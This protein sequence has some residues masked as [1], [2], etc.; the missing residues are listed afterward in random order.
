[1]VAQD[2]R[3]V[4]DRQHDR[5]QGAIVRA[6]EAVPPLPSSRMPSR[7]KLLSIVVIAPTGGPPAA[8]E[9]VSYAMWLNAACLPGHGSPRTAGSAWTAVSSADSIHALRE[10]SQFR[11]LPVNYG[12]RQ[13]AASARLG[14]RAGPDGDRPVGHGQQRPPDPIRSGTET[15][16]TTTYAPEAQRILAGEPLLLEF[17]PPGY[18]FILALA[19]RHAGGLVDSGSLDSGLAA[20]CCCSRAICC[21]RASPGQPA[22]SGAL[23]ACACSGVFHAFASS[24]TSDMPFAAL[25][26]ATLALAVV[27]I[28]ERERTPCWIVTG[29]VA[30]ITVLFRP[31]ASRSSSRWP[32]HCSSMLPGRIG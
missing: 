26:C 4:E 12:E 8:T 23:A 24:A 3:F 10:G 2:R 5:D 13:S 30:A 29:L 15:D 11:D 21:S 14:R 18:P 22:A 16:F 1:M 32:R 25:V 17:H 27:G 28:Q 31:M 19:K 9:P 20:C 6:A 7:K